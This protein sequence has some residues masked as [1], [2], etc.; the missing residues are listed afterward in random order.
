MKK[1]RCFL[2]GQDMYE[3]L[4]SEYEERTKRIRKV[5]REKCCLM[6][7]E[8]LDERSEK[9]VEKNTLDLDK[10][11]DKKI[12][13][14]ELLTDEDE[15]LEVLTECPGDYSVG[16]TEGYK[17]ALERVKKFIEET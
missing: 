3:P 16:H 9:V 1:K 6:E 15:I 2:C 5:L 13:Q 7:L 14:L 17:S 10:W 11:L 4:L 12:E 8:E